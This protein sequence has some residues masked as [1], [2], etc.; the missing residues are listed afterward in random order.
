VI[1]T[2]ED[3]E[4]REAA[5]L[6]FFQSQSR[7]PYAEGTQMPEVGVQDIAQVHIF[8]MHPDMTYLHATT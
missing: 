7:Q 3:M 1:S 8:A 5:S 4:A 2:Q 6:P